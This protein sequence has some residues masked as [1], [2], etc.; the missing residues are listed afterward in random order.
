METAA[1]LS[2]S[3]VKRLM[4]QVVAPARIPMSC[5]FCS[6][7]ATGFEYGSSK[8]SPSERTLT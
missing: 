3:S 8:S 1:R 4:E 2:K 5:F 7:A 6:T